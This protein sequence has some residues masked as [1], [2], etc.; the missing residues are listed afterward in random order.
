MNINNLNKFIWLII[1]LRHIVFYIKLKGMIKVIFSTIDEATIKPIVDRFNSDYPNATHEFNSDEEELIFKNVSENIENV[2][3]FLCEEI[4]HE[5]EVYCYIKDLEN[6]T[7]KN[8]YYD[9]E[10]EWFYK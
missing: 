10:D 8:Y 2:D 9:E 7:S 4:C 6:S 5:Y 1:Y 3:T